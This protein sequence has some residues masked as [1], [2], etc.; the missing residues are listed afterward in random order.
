MN[1]RCRI[2]FLGDAAVGKTCIASKISESETADTYTPTIHANY[3]SV[4]VA[5][6]DRK[7]QFDIWDTAGQE[8][9]K[10]LAPSYCRDVNG[11]WV[12]FDVTRKETLENTKDWVTI[13]RSNSPGAKIVL[14]GNKCDLVGERTVSAPE[15]AAVAD[16]L[17]VD[18]FE[19][20]ALTGERL[21]DAFMEL[22][23]QCVS[24][25]E[26]GVQTAN[27]ADTDSKR[28]CCG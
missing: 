10:S 15:G 17:G 7:T 5:V 12:V 3:F 16:E 26:M 4:F 27:P 13:L 22:A 18:Y 1:V 24:S 8:Q 23:T 6:E 21:K 14:F 11:A 9:Y 2:V 28:S 25:A 20:S 19:G